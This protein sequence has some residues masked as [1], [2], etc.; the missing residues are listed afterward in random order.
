MKASFY[1]MEVIP[2]LL[3]KRITR[4]GFSYTTGTGYVPFKKYKEG[5]HFAE[6]M[7]PLKL[8]LRKLN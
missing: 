8:K 6:E 2:E 3:T 4:L 7:E 1:R 5:F